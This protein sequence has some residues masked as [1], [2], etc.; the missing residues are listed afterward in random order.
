MTQVEAVWTRSML[1]RAIWCWRRIVKSAASEDVAQ[2][3]WWN[4]KHVAIYFMRWQQTME[5]Q[6]AVSWANTVFEDLFVVKRH[7]F[8]FNT[9][10]LNAQLLKQAAENLL[11]GL[12]CFDLRSLAFCFAFWRARVETAVKTAA[13]LRQIDGRWKRKQLVHAFSRWVFMA[14]W[15]SRSLEALVVA[16][17]HWPC[18][19]LACGFTHWAHRLQCGPPIQELQRQVAVKILRTKTTREEHTNKPSVYY[20]MRVQFDS[21]TPLEVRRRY[22][23]FDSLDRLLREQFPN[24]EMPV[25]PPK[26]PIGSMDPHFIATRKTTLQ[27]YLTELLQNSTVAN[28]PAMANFLG[29]GEFNP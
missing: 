2:Q 29:T 5:A 14:E 1:A 19:L 25:L 21:E 20:M 22:M 12:L 28:A 15:Q 9:W 7:G 16:V 3:I 8:L 4:K 27:T 26:K 13:S 17:K 18:R 24:L 11:R 10:R 23:D 6:G